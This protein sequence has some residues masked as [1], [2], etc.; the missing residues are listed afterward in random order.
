MIRHRV[1]RFSRSTTW[2]TACE[3]VEEWINAYVA[4][5]N[6]VSVAIEDNED[7]LGNDVIIIWY[8]EKLMSN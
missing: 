8:R 3:E 4:P 2:E 6:L 7:A 5:E 1:F